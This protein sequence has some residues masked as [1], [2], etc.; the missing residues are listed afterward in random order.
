MKYDYI[1]SAVSTLQNLFY[2]F[3]S[4]RNDGSALV[5]IIILT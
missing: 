3:S 5:T 2:A 1:Q 4:F